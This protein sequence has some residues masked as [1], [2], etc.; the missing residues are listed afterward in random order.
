MGVKDD[1]FHKIADFMSDSW[2]EMLNILPALLLALWGGLI[3]QLP[4]WLKWVIPAVATVIM[5]VSYIF[6]F[7]KNKSLTK[8]EATIEE[9]GRKIQAQ[10]SSL[11]KFG[12]ENAALFNYVLY[13]LSK[14]IGLK[15]TDRISVYKK[16]REKFVTIGRYSLNP[17]YSDIRRSSI[18]TSEGFIG[19]ALVNGEC[20]VVGIEEPYKK[21]KDSPYNEK[22]K[23]CCNITDD[24]LEAI[25]MKSRFYYCKALTDQTGMERTSVIVIESTNANRFTRE[26]I[27]AKIRPEE[28]KIQAFVEKCRF[29]PVK[30]IEIAKKEGF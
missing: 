19:K 11:E 30:D 21:K 5:V 8:C 1:G 26:E 7:K 13:I 6:I 12:Q 24:V 28:D 10:E 14:N 20:L 22:I 2:P 17:N 23:S 25:R 3:T 4:E 9:Q 27:T 15:D 16:S 29:S 18:P